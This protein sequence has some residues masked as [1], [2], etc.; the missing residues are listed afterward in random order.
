MTRSQAQALFEASFKRGTSVVIG[1]SRVRGDFKKESDIDIG[2]GSL[3]KRQAQRILREF[4]KAGEEE[5]EGAT[6]QTGL[7]PEERIAIVPGTETPNISKIESPE[8]FFMRSG[9]RAPTDPKTGRFEPS[10]YI[11]YDP[12][13]S[14]IWVSSTGARTVVK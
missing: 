5:T 7:L 4:R 3:S 14:I 1:G 13:G 12:S 2:F 8:E 11:S 6:V 10:G 9:E